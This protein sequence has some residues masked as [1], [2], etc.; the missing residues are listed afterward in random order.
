MQNKKKF[1]GE[2]LNVTS[3]SY[4]EKYFCNI[5]LTEE[6]SI[7]TDQCNPVVYSLLVS[8]PGEMPE[9][10]PVGCCYGRQ[11]HARHNTDGFQTW[12]FISPP[13]FLINSAIKNYEFRVCEIAKS[14]K[15]CIFGAPV[16][17]SSCI[18]HG[19][20]D[21]IATPPVW[22]SARA[23]RLATATAKTRDGPPCCASLR[24]PK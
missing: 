17:I 19:G 12:I 10:C 18:I 5:Y 21:F 3:T 8:R 15:I 14:S 1:Y 11:S 2:G 22:S 4:S 7:Y 20:R 13:I 9:S 6:K 23:S 24:S 16:L